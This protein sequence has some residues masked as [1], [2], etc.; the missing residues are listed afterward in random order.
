MPI[1]RI[2][3]YAPRSLMKSKPPDADERIEARRAE[4][5]DLRIEA[6]RPAGA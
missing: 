1:V 5:A 4:L 6:A 2:G 3:M